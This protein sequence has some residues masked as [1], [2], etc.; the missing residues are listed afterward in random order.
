MICC[1]PFG[2][3]YLVV[4]G[5]VA[6]MSW[7]APPRLVEIRKRILRGVNKKPP[8]PIKAWNIKRGDKVVYIVT[9]LI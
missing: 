3:L 7:R 2:D 9:F 6:T 1:A 8:E 4:R 5:N